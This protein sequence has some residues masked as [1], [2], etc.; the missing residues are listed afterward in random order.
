MD[1]KRAR[2]KKQPIIGVLRNQLPLCVTNGQSYKET[3]GASVEQTS[4]SYP[5]QG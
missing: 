2:E 3:L 5:T 1:N 4:Q